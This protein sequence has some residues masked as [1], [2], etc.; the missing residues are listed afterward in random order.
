MKALRILTA[1]ALYGG[2]IVSGV[3]R[4]QEAPPAP[5]APESAQTQDNT[6]KN[7]AQRDA[8]A[9]KAEAEK[10]QQK[11]DQAQQDKD[12]QKS[13][14]QAQQP[15]PRM[16]LGVRLAPSR[17]RGVL[18]QDIRP[19]GSAD[20]AG[21]RRGDYILSV[22]EKKVNSPEDLMGAL[23]DKAAGETITI[24]VW[25]DGASQQLTAKLQEAPQP[26]NPPVGEN[27]REGQEGRR[28]MTMRPNIEGQQDS[29]PWI[30]IWMEE[31]PSANV[32]QDPNAPPQP[33]DNQAQQGQP[34]QGQPQ[35]GVVVR[36]VFPSGP[37]ARGGLR[38]GDVIVSIGDKKVA[39]P[40]ELIDHIGSL[41]PNDTV[42]FSVLRGGQTTT[43]P[44]VIG[45]RSDYAEPEMQQSN[46][47]GGQFAGQEGQD[48]D[49]FGSVPDHSMM[50]EQHRRFAEQHERL[51]KLILELKEDVRQLREELRGKP[52]QQQGEAP[53]KS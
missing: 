3:S 4:A 9:K 44:I 15:R 7:D 43:L 53:G 16:E 32:P 45:Q 46:F 14:A 30:G 31:Q 6:Q 26:P 28:H 38:D 37:A 41:K 22:G 42:Q 36:H 2:L 49:D 27:D 8:E 51:E 39:S 11:D 18:V 52:A 21:V 40:Q 5:S 12:Q 35:Q 50:L 48:D 24:E 10:N 1:T 47:Q 19:G 20:Q 23:G 17:T 29:S 13:D 33:S 25:R 34:Q